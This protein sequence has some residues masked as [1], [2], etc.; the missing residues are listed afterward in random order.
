MPFFVWR[1]AYSVGSEAIDNQHKQLFELAELLR[2]ALQS[3]DVESV[4]EDA[5]L[6]LQSYARE[7]FR[8]EEILFQNCDS[9]LLA[10][11]RQAHRQLAAE[12]EEMVVDRA[13]GYV[14]L[15]NKLVDWVN[16][17]LLQ[18]I[19]VEDTKAWAARQI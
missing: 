2:C 9:A 5:L 14:D 3:E 18:H 11:H 4:V 7:H 19:L 1:T 12:I 15:Q 10:Q 13:V 8:D 16:R 6:A 17:R